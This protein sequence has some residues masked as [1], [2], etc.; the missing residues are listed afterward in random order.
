MHL[1]SKR[2]SE[3]I[4]L[5]SNRGLS[6]N[7]LIGNR[8][9]HSLGRNRSL[10]SIGSHIEEFKI[11]EEF[12]SSITDWK[13]EANEQFKLGNFKESAELFGRILE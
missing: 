7:R 5:N 13:I 3:N 10:Q 2:S 11:L 9:L 6:K 1:P 8:S 4:Y 12:S